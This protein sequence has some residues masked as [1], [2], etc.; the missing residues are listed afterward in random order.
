LNHKLEAKIQKQIRK[1]AFKCAD[2]RRQERQIVQQTE[3]T[4]DA[5]QEVTGLPRPH[6]DSIAD[7]VRLSRQMT[8]DD[9]FSIKDQI[10]WIFGLT[11]L[12]L[13]LSGLVYII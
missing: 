11:S 1:R 12:I 13:I 7:E 3:Y 4:L 10:L 2:I 5:L 8:R 9:F 6:L